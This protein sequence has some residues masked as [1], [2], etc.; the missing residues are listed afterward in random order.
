M[1]EIRALLWLLMVFGSGRTEI[2]EVIRKYGSAVNAQYMLKHVEELEEKPRLSEVLLRRIRQVGDAEVSEMMQRIGRKGISILSYWDAAYPLCLKAVANPPVLLFYIGDISLLKKRFLL[3]VVG[4][5]NPTEY[6]LKTER[7]LCHDLLRYDFIFVTGF[8]VG[9][10]ITANTCALEAGK[11]SIAVM[12]C[13]LDVDYPRHY[14]LKSKIAEKGLLL[15]EF[16]PGISPEPSNFPLR[17]RVMSGLSRGTLVVQAPVRSGALITANYAAEQGREVFCIPP[18]NI[19]D[20]RYMGVADFL[21]EGA[22]PVFGA[23]DIYETYCMNY[24]YVSTK[25]ELSEYQTKKLE[26]AYGI[27]EN[28]QPAAKPKEHRQ[29]SVIPPKGE[30]EAAKEIDESQYNELQRKMIALLRENVV[31]QIDAMASALDVSLDTLTMELTEL[32]LG[33]VIVNMPGKQYR[34]LM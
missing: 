5:R 15:S 6:S 16:L 20:N 29:E 7:R 2:H 14:M 8:A 34:L 31:M 13:G 21:R 30:K 18:A 23:E 11:P 26:K 4:T 22:V 32:E 1:D 3:T 25:E 17:N 9:A 28:R 33:D 12:G 27:G 24:A 10:D 19:Y